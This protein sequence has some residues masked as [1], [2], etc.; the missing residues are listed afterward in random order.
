MKGKGAKKQIMSWKQEWYLI[1]LTSLTTTRV[2]LGRDSKPVRSS[3][4]KTT[5]QMQ[6]AERRQGQHWPRSLSR[7]RKGVERR[8]GK[9]R[10]G[11]KEEGE[12][13]DSNINLT[14][15]EETGCAW[16]CWN[17]LFF[18]SWTVHALFVWIFNRASSLCV[19]PMLSQSSAIVLGLLKKLMVSRKGNR[20]VQSA[21]TTR[22][23]HVLR[24]PQFFVYICALLSF[25]I[26]D[27]SVPHSGRLLLLLFL[28][29]NC[30]P[31]PS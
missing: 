19:V 5:G 15:Q 11:T 16:C 13:K 17:A 14:S 9:G 20:E 10:E 18:V 30:E 12:D 31:I 23:K 7:S 29:T 25:F 27:A 6:T 2:W 3:E 4:M 22:R 24:M 1:A 26:L 28:R 21:Q 8:E